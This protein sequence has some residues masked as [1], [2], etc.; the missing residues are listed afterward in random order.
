MVRGDYGIGSRMGAVTF[1][2]IFLGKNFARRAP[3]YF[4]SCS[5]IGILIFKFGMM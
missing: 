5:S 3:P 2:N 4:G 1:F